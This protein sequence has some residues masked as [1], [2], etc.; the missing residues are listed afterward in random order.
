MNWLV[1][2]EIVGIVLLVGA[3]SFLTALFVR[4]RWLSTRG[5]VVDCGLRK[6]ND[7]RGSA[8]TMGIARYEGEVFEWYRVFSVS[9]RPKVVFPRASTHITGRRQIDDLEALALFDDHDIISVT[10]VNAKGQPGAYELS[11]TPAS[12]TGLMSWLEASPPGGASYRA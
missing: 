8:W 11:M 3:V 4:R 6:D 1:A 12:V 5:G 9:F 7:R 10:S 2:A